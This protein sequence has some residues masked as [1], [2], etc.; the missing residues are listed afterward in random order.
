MLK[1]NYN[2]V[3]LLFEDPLGK[4]M[5]AFAIVTQLIGAIVIKKIVNIKI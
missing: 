2:Y 3:M 5:L 1:L 4:Q